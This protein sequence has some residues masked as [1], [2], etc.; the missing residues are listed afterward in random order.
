M[1]DDE[2][3]EAFAGR[4]PILFAKPLDSFHAPTK[5][6]ILHVPL[7]FKVDHPHGWDKLAGSTF[8]GGSMLGVPAALS[9]FRKKFGRERPRSSKWKFERLVTSPIGGFTNSLMVERVYINPL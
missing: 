3:S 4:I 8:R 1:S 5:A 2:H 9:R 7:W 6:K